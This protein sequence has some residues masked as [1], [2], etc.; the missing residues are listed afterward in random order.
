MKRWI[1]KALILAAVAYAM[2]RVWHWK[3]GFTYFTQLSNLFVAGTMLL[4][5]CFP[6]KRWALL[7]FAASVSILLT[8]LTYLAVLVPL[9][10][11]GLLAAYRQDHYASLCMHLIVPLLTLADF[12]INDPDYPWQQRH[13]WLAMIP[14]AVYLVFVLALGAAGLRWY[15]GMPVPYPFLNYTAPAGWFGFRPE[16]VGMTSVG[17]GA[18]YAIFAMM[19][20]CAGIGFALKHLA[21]RRGKRGA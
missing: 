12:M 21:C 15:A 2:I 7:K 14:P 6:R 8:G 10:P 1:L 3:I 11:G 19:L 13:V 18:A 4:Q 20:L 5:L 16:T 9:E 17:I